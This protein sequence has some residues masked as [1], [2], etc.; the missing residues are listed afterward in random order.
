MMSCAACHSNIHN[1]LNAPSQRHYP[2]PQPSMSGRANNNHKGNVGN[3]VPLKHYLPAD[4]MATANISD[5]KLVAWRK[6]LTKLSAQEALEHESRRRLQIVAAADDDDDDVHRNEGNCGLK[7]LKTGGGDVDGVKRGKAEC[8]NIKV[9]PGGPTVTAAAAAGRVLSDAEDQGFHDDE[10]G[11]EV[12][13]E[14]IYSDDHIHLNQSNSNCHYFYH[15]TQSTKWLSPG[16]MFARGKSQQPPTA[17][18]Y[19]YYKNRPLPNQPRMMPMVASKGVLEMSTDYQTPYQPEVKSPPPPPVT[20]KGPSRL[21][22]FFQNFS[23]PSSSSDSSSSSLSKAVAGVADDKPKKKNKETNLALRSSS[24]FFLASNSIK[25]NRHKNEKKKKNEKSSDDSSSCSSLSSHSS[26]NFFAE[27]QLGQAGRSKPYR[28]DLLQMMSN[29]VTELR[30]R[31]SFFKKLISSSTSSSPSSSA[32]SSAYSNCSTD[33][34][35]SRLKSKKLKEL[36]DYDYNNDYEEID[37][38]RHRSR[39]FSCCLPFR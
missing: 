21:Q 9:F 32:S 29:S 22:T 1:Q 28:S 11:I 23:R 36:Y 14:P 20:A 7:M 17:S 4:R 31:K 3:N 19:H 16:R 10:G 37:N 30:N 34:E 25:K 35:K 24:F 5:A 39:L 38:E 18:V 33:N 12:D 8:A 27:Q 2:T 26:R 15:P 6:S 13:D